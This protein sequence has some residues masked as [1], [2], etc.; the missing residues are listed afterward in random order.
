[1]VVYASFRSKCPACG[2]WIEEDDEIVK[3]EDGEWVHVECAE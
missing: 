2:D 1:M 3:T